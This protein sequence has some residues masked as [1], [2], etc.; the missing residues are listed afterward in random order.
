MSR[1][2]LI[3]TFLLSI[4]QLSFGQSR[5]VEGTIISGDD[6]TP[7]PGVNV[8]IKGTTI[9]TS[10]DVQ[11]KY[12][13]EIPG[14]DAVL[15]FTFIGYQ[16]VEETVGTRSLIDVTL[17]VD[18]QT[19]DEV[20]VVGYGTVKKSDLTGAVSSVN[21]SDLVKI[22]SLNPTQAL[23]GKVAGV[24][25]TN[26]SG[27]PGASPVVRI[28]GVGTFNNSSPIYVVDGVILD[29][30]N[31]LNAGDIQSMEVLK[32][33]SATAIYGSR[34]ANGVIL[35]TTKIGKRG[36]ESSSF[37]FSADF[38]MQRLQKHIDLLGGKDFANVVNDITPGTF[39]NVDA[40]ANTDWQDEI[41]RTAPIQNY[42]VSASGSSA[43]SQ[44]YFGLGYFRQD[45]IIPKS[46]YERLTIKLNNIYHI[47]KNIRLGNNITL[48]PTE[49]QN[50]AGGAV[51]A[52]YRAQPVIAPF[53][54]NGS[55]APVTGAGNPLAAIEYTNSF[56]KSIRAVGNVYG[57]ID[58]LK[59][60]TF[61][62][63][64]GVDADY[65]MNRNFTP[66]FF[67]SPTQQNNPNT[68]GKDW[69]QRMSW[70]L[71]N[72]LNFK[73]EFGKHRVDALVGYTM[74]DITS[75]NLY[76]QARN[77]IRDD[78][79]FWYINSDNITDQNAYR[80][81]KNV[82]DAN[83]FYSMMSVLGRINYTY[84]DR[85]LFTATF[86]RDGSSKFPERN[87]FASFP[88]L[89]A[90]WNII[91]EDFM[92]QHPKI[93]NLK[94]RASWGIVGNEKIDYKKQYSVV[95]NGI[96]SVFGSN[97]VVVPGQTYAGAGN[98][99]VT[100]E[101]TY[102]TDIGV[103][104]G[105]FDD[106]L[107]A[108]IDYFRRDTKDILIDLPVPGY[109]GNGIGATITYNAGE[110]LN[111]GVELSLG[112]KGEIGEFGYK[113]AGNATTIHNETLA[114]RGTGGSDDYLQGIFNS[115]VVT[116]TNVGSPIGSFFGYKVDGVFQNAAEL[117]AYPHRL[118]A[119]VGDLRYVDADGNGVLND[120]DRVNL[121][122]PIPTALYGLNLEGSYKSFEVSIDFN[123]QS[124]NKIYNG[125]ETVRPDLYNFEQ[126]V[127][128]RWRGEGTS[129]TEPRATAGGY[130][131]IPSD[132]FIQDGSYLRLRSVS[133]SYNIPKEIAERM[134]MTAARVYVRGTNI[135][136]KTKFTGYTPEIASYSVDGLLTSPLLTGIDAGSYPVPAVY[137]V[138]LNVTF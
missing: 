126:H 41:F 111:R 30:I 117:A 47:S 38:S 109:L 8:V 57:E 74:Q 34:G 19:L 29:D 108:E 120:G 48:S 25:V 83:N 70:L 13:L 96:S 32:D 97:E 131:W 49:S 101:S 59:G 43:K 98:P 73:K 76:L 129:S 2:L 54:A 123:G 112:W 100:W 23:M 118:D 105:F 14:D 125:K 99:D 93:T 45:G 135:F 79:S 121:G 35:I 36:A 134:R 37:S 103:E 138:G 18:T 26:T 85:F 50:T 87:R 67:V 31:F 15:Q 63:S 119:G 53:Q 65:T 46:Q 115:N 107:T 81:V 130:N 102:Q 86:R 75:Q 82:V 44:Y 110:V 124:G 52:V 3:I 69:N 89:A 80:E 17:P 113:V 21:G 88:S 12:R 56:A 28:R 27:A 55:F 20:V 9:G 6:K 127:I 94:V 104:L 122:S 92:K 68:L 58:F 78:P 114:V 132:R 66:V 72:T 116:R 22:P 33:A 90:G 11:G 7:M 40:V 60:F 71:E 5:V 62:S 77:V 136:T 95:A 84:D 106:R 42:Q 64:F 16:T 1:K 10:T 128:N 91:N 24:Q 4:F 133:I 51:F 61:K 137:S 39:N